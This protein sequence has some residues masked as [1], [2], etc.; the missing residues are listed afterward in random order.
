[1]L[2]ASRSPSMA[3]PI[4]R[5]SFFAISD[6]REIFC[7]VRDR[8]PDELKRLKRAYSISHS[9]T[10]PPSTPSPSSVLFG[11][12]YD[13]V[14]RTLVGLITLRWI[15]NDQYDTFRASQPDAVA[16]TRDSFCW[17]QQVFKAGL[18]TD[19]DFIALLTS[20]VVNDLG[21]DPQ[22]ASDYCAKTG[23]DISAGNHDLIL[24][25]AAE[26]GLVPS[27]DS[28]PDGDRADVLRGMKLGAEFNFGQLAQGENVPASLTALLELR[29]HPRA[30]EL[31]FMEQLLDI[32]G[33]RGHE[34]WTC[35]K[36]M[37]QPVFDAYRNVYDAVQGVISGSMDLRAAYDLILVRRAGMLRAKGFR[38]LDVTSRED[39]AL[40]RLL[41]MGGVA[42]METAQLYDSVWAGLPAETK[43]SLVADLN[44][45]GSVQ[46]PAVQATYAPAL[47][48]KGVDANGPGSTDAKRGRLQ[49][50]LCYLSRVLRPTD[51]YLEE[52]AV[53]IERN[54]LKVVQEIVGSGEFRA[55][56]AML[57]GKAVPE[58][59]VA[60]TA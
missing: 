4:D 17:I 21:K 59:V 20:I 58:A 14:N 53:V 16:L 40:M 32:A 31:R 28:L 6:D 3:T 30:F 46:V 42:D 38:R 45:D 44:V 23:E 43:T 57:D 49:S 37:T 10:T 2:S 5:A 35:A 48:T 11:E 56:P 27:L 52:R 15:Y 34:D 60:Q 51:A 41:C 47:L 7:L 55:N 19:N 1:M 29:G 33:A 25:K 39:R 13:E 24:L 54:V 22:L 36:T 8:F 9:N 18:K 26:A 12:Q 50:L